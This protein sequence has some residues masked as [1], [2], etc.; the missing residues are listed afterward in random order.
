MLLISR[1]ILYRIRKTC[2]SV[3]NSAPESNKNV[4]NCNSVSN[5]APESNRNVKNCNPVSNS[6]P[7]SNRNVKNRNSVSNSAPESNRIAS[8]AVCVSNSAHDPIQEQEKSHSC[9]AHLDVPLYSFVK[10]LYHVSRSRKS[11]PHLI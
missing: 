5:S 1:S 11:S 6:A 9:F 7:E 3:S 10:S 2:N 8:F 4:K